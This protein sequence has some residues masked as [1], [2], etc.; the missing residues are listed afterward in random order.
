MKEIFTLNT[1]ED[2]SKNRLIVKSQK[3]KKI[4]YRYIKE[5]RSKN[6]EFTS[7]RNKKF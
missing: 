4:W 2:A 6:M 1:R 7:Y 3:S 5:S